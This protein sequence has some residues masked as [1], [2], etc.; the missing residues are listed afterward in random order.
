MEIWKDIP[1]YEGCYQVSNLGRLKSLKMNKETILKGGI[2]STGYLKFCL[3]LNRK[4]KYYSMHQLVAMAF[5][6]HKPCGYKLVVN[7]KNFNRLDNRLENLEVI[8]HRE[9]TNRKHIK[10]KS[11]YVGV[12]WSSNINKYR[13]VIL[14][15]GK[16]KILGQFDDEK[17]ASNYYEKA[18]ISL[19]NGSEIEVKR[20][21]F[22]SK[23]KGVT[24]F[25]SRKKWLA[26][27]KVD[28][29]WKFVGYF[30]TEELAKEHL[31]K[32]NTL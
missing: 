11:K 5:L 17:E 32:L 22:S 3:I 29:K 7:H 1:N 15:N 20:A 13:A 2:S 27:I 21:V 8:T 16:D 12:Q 25:K 4:T 28:N 30:D 31:T 6:N 26:R 19:K 24:F 18:L 9:N 23:Y 14:I 10:S